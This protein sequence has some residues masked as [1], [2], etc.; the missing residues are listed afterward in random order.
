MN[1]LFL[2]VW[3][4]ILQRS[5]SLYFWEGT[6]LEKEAWKVGS[7]KAVVKEVYVQRG[8][9][10]NSIM[11]PPRC[12]RHVPF[13]HRYTSGCVPSVR[14]NRSLCEPRPFFSFF[15]FL[16]IHFFVE[17]YTRAKYTS[18]YLVPHRRH[19]GNQERRFLSLK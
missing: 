7:S 8:V 2:N 14:F 9:T 18:L 17:Y 3:N 1:L 16:F 12:S 5:I 6:K 15:I 11:R 19:S 10:E 4:D 13:L